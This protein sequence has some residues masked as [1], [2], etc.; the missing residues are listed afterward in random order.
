MGIR[1]L[2]WG[3]ST[4][5]K[6]P[7]SELRDVLIPLD[8]VLAGGLEDLTD[9]LSTGNPDHWAE[10]V[11]RSLWALAS[12]QPEAATLSVRAFDIIGSSPRPISVR[13]LARTL[14]VGERHLERL[15][16][17]DVGLPPVVLRRILRI[18]RA[19]W[20]MRCRPGRP[21]SAVALEAGY[22]DQPHFVREFRRVVGWTPRG[23]CRLN[24]S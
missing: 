10:T 1:L 3:A 21:L 17:R 9:L 23:S 13:E 2:P 20:M 11:F 4:L 24:W 8:S 16:R 12:E 22:Y 7:V 18:Q 15:M 14:H 19:L 5:L 6:T